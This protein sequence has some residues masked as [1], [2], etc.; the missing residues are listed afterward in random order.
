MRWS[1]RGSLRGIA[2]AGRLGLGE[3]LASLGSGALDEPVGPG[4]TLTLGEGAQDAE[5]VALRVGEHHPAGAGAV[6]PAV[7][8]DLDGAVREQAGELVVAGA[9][10]RLEVRC[11]RFFTVLPSGTSMNSSRC[12]PS[13]L[14]IMHSAWPGR[15]G[16]PST[17]P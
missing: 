8:G 14:T 2:D 1:L 12:V 17:S 15:F 4:G 5:L 10:D 6:L 11:S 3:R 16:S 13:G 7:V 9:L